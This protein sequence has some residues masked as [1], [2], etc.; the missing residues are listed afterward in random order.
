MSDA[1]TMS[2]DPPEGVFVVVPAYNEAAAIGDVLR[3]LRQAGCA[4]AI[5]VDD[6][7]TDGTYDAARGKARY[8]L[9]HAVNRGQ[10][11]A[12][13]TGIEFALSR[14]ARF[15]VTFDADGQHDCESI[16]AL[17]EPLRRGECEITLGSRFLGQAIDLPMSRRIM[18][19]LAVAFTRLVNGVSLTDAHNGLRGFSRH[20]AER[21]DIRL[22]R[23]AHASELIDL[24]VRSGLSYR[25]VP[26][27]VHYTQYSLNKG[28]S[29][30]G[31]LRILF[32][33]LVGRVV[34]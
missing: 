12:L 11:A 17:V 5:V 23:M 26:V 34:R 29:S 2:A 14:G 3:Q 21:V 7:S 22:D 6:G 16:A 13:Q 25:E 27:K 18:L 1:P 4:N 19:R 33:Y 24:I 32:H 20:A 9:R 31:A 8:L 30:R 10:G 28:Q 15:V